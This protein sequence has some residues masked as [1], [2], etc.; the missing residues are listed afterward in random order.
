M[1]FRV[2]WH[3]LPSYSLTVDVHEQSLVLSN[4][5]PGIRAKSDMYNALKQY[6]VSLSAEDRPL[7]RRIDSERFRVAAISQR[8][9]IALRIAARNASLECTA[10]A[11]VSLMQE[12]F[13]G[14]LIDGPFYDYR[15]NALGMNPDRAQ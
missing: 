9:G 10:K 5:L 7:H 11:L 3:G 14:F 13:Y 15:V 2:A 6:L 4:V 8:N 12:F 1:T